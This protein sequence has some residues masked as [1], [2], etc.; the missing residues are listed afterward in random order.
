M[1]TDDVTISRMQN[2]FLQ[3]GKKKYVQHFYAQT[4]KVTIHICLSSPQDVFVLS[5]VEEEQSCSVSLF[6]QG[7]K[8][9][10]VYVVGEK[11][12]TRWTRQL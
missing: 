2:L 4:Q 10:C 7:K 1:N 6:M 5:S 9:S 11:E 3:F 12:V 8:L